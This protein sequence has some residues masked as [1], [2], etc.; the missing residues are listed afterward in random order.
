MN[1]QELA[2]S[3]LKHIGGEKNVNQLIH[4]ATRLRFV[5][6]D[7]S[8]VHVEEIKALQGVIGVV[9]SGGQFQI[10]I[11]NDVISVYDP[12]MK[13]CKLDQGKK[14]HEKGKKGIGERLIETVSSIFMPLLPVITAA[15]M[16]K[17]VLALL[18]VTKLIDASSQSYQIIS[19]M[20]DAAFYFLPPILAASAA[21][22]F[23][24]DM[25][26]A[27]MIGGILLH[28]NFVNMVAASKE[29][30]EAIRLFMIPFYNASYSSTV[31]PIILSIWVMSYVE[32][33]AKKI[34][35]KMVSYFTVPLITILV[36]GT[37][38]LSILGP[39]GFIAGVYIADTVKL[40]DQYCGW[41][42]PMLV[43]AFMPLMIMT[44]THYSILPIGVNNVMTMGYDT[45]VGPGTMMAN[46][47]V[48][49]SALAVGFK[50]K[51]EKLKSLGFTTGATAVCGITEP[52][53][54][55]M[56]LRNKK[57]LI[58]TIIGGAAGGLFAGLFGVRRFALGNPGLLTI[59]V[60]IGGEGI[61]NFVYACIGCAIAFVITFILSYLWHKDD[62][63][64]TN[65][66]A[67]ESKAELT[68]TGEKGL[69][70]YAPVNGTA[71]PLTSVNDPVFKEGVMGKGGA[72]IPSDGHFV[73]PVSGTV[74]MVFETKHAIGIVS[75]NGSEILLHVG[76]DTVKLEGKYF[77]ALVKTGDRVE[78]GTP[79]LDVDIEQVKAEGYDVVTPVIITNS[80]Q[81]GS[82]ISVEDG[83]IH[84][85]ET[86]IKAL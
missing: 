64:E 63:D 53:L 4:C 86:F 33:F 40:I 58:A 73:S 47:A 80:I 1:Y 43:G 14:G 49:A 31:L 34:S 65:E 2:E 83:S 84:A 69:T 52:A 46:F 17:A 62:Q 19:F 11:G 8:K 9:N 81:Y 79:I 7:E 21:K 26:L 22:R 30:G 12:L 29:S 78:V 74:K 13:L 41:L 57:L 3:I 25:F 68:F 16:L 35:P 38:A 23:G 39:I 28:P 77:N 71:I 18:I 61:S 24:C 70:V 6:K 15:G 54:F 76:L 56:V 10:I 20:A 50:S 48:G 51:K 60:Y 27:I 36:T 66:E 72:I 44:G 82:V 85:K 37:L 59:P 55:G 67:I 45:I 75:D 42:I 5:L 32:R